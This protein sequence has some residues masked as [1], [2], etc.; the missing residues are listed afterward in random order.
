MPELARADVSVVRC[1]ARPE[2][3]DALPAPAGAFACRVAPD[4]LILIGAHAASDEILAACSHHLEEGLALDHTDAF[5]AWAI[6]GHQAGEVFAR[7][8][9][10]RLPDE[11]PAFVQGAVAGVPAKVLAEADRIVVLVSSV[12]GHHLG[13]RLEEATA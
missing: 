2:V 8:S 12:L 4:E 9:A 6:S 10:M 3:L 11:R 1:L 13:E 7:L 5:A